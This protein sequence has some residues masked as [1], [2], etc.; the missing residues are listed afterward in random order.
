MRNRSLFLTSVL[1]LFVTPCFSAEPERLR[2][3]KILGD[4]VVLQQGKPIT[5]WGWA[6]PG[7]AIKVTL[8][9]D[10]TTGKKAEEDA[11]LES[12]ADEGDDYSVKVR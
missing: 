4:N 3:A 8:T 5:I 1:A 6:K 10:A 9:Q 12:K 11:G 2:I 7:A